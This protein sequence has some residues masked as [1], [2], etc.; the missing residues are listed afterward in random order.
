MLIKKERKKEHI[1]LPES[2]NAASLKFDLPRKQRVFLHG[3]IFARCLCV[4]I[5]ELNRPT[6]LGTALPMFTVG[7]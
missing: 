5:S 4:K 1:S 6:K 7:P 2:K 3:D